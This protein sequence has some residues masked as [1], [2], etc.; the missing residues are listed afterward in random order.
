[1]YMHKL[2]RKLTNKFGFSRFQFVTNHE[3]L[4]AK[5]AQPATHN[6]L[7]ALASDPANWQFPAKPATCRLGVLKLEWHFVPP[8][9]FYS[10][11]QV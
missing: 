6:C 9:C 1:M 11:S 8:F 2:S 10:S 5:P 7:A 4:P 3:D